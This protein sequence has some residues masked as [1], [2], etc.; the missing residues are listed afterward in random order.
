MD[1]H[2]VIEWINNNPI[3]FTCLFYLTLF[4]ISYYVIILMN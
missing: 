3:E 2:K 4:S 1:N